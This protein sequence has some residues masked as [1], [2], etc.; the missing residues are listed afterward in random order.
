MSV[1]IKHFIGNSIEYEEITDVN[2]FN[3]NE[4]SDKT[5]NELDKAPSTSK[6]DSILNH[7]DKSPV[8]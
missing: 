8:S 2:M 6:A 3:K 4:K 5:L 1:P 7:E